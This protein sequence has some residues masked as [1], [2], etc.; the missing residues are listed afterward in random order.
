[1]YFVRLRYV[2]CF[3]Y[4]YMDMVIGHVFIGVSL[5][6][7]LRKKLLNRFSKNVVEKW[8][9]PTEETSIIFW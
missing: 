6:G 1:M 5:L 8:Q 2:N 7:G 3:L 9:W 4:E